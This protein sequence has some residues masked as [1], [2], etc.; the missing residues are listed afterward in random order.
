MAFYRCTFQFSMVTGEEGNFTL[1]V[2]GASTSAPGLATVAADAATL[3]MNGAAPP[4]DNIDQFVPTTVTIDQVVVDE[5]D[6]SGR[7]ISQAVASIAQ[8]GSDTSEE[9]PPQC[10]VAVSTRSATP[11]RAG[12]G[13]FFL[14]PYGVDTVA[15]GKLTSTGRTRTATAA[16]KFLQHFTANGWTPVIFH[17]GTAVETD[18]TAIDVG[19]VFDTQRR[20]RNQQTETRTRL[21]I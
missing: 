4:A 1:H 17:K 19:D 10:S 5:I 14:P 7:N 11:T 20:R 13:R 8:A 18:I 9:L 15:S 2:V 21:T 12:R 3:L 16:Q 6:T